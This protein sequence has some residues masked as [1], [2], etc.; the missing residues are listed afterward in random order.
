MKQRP[1]D[2]RDHAAHVATSHAPSGHPLVQPLGADLDLDHRAG[3][4]GLLQR[5]DTSFLR[6]VLIMEL[7]R[8]HREVA[9]G[10]RAIVD[11]ELGCSP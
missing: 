9:R 8:H 11:Q 2:P 1:V 6:S 4:Q 3:T 10:H 7:D 5:A